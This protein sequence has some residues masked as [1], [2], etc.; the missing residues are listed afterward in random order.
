M[1]DIKQILKE[2]DIYFKENVPLYTVLKVRQKSNHPDDAHLYMV[3]AI[4][5]DGTYAVWTCWN[6][7]TKSLNFGHYDLPDEETCEKIMDGFQYNIDAYR[8]T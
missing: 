3:S 8:S 2:V 4:K 5:C 6:N 1:T 7:S